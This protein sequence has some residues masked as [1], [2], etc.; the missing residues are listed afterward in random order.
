MLAAIYLAIQVGLLLS[1]KLQLFHERTRN[2]RECDGEGTIRCTN[3]LGNGSGCTKCNW[4]KRMTC[5]ICLG[6]RVV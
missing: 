3:C 6:K 1:P 2:C 5:P 4:T